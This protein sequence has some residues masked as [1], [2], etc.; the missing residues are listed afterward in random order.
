LA[1]KTPA[2][3]RIRRCRREKERLRG[4]DLDVVLVRGLDPGETPLRLDQDT[5]AHPGEQG[6]DTVLGDRAA[7]VLD[8][9]R[10]PRL[11]PFPFLGERGVPVAAEQ[12]AESPRE[13]RRVLE[14]QPGELP[15]A[16]P[17]ELGAP[18]RVLAHIR[19]FEQRLVARPLSLVIEERAE[20]LERQQR[21]IELVNRLELSVERE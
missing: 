18:K 11:E 10:E 20:K 8:R 17:V 5:R 3:A 7:R 12:H 15:A 2:S 4:R 16:L 9:V 13:L 1:D 19:A 21:R 6:E 14:D